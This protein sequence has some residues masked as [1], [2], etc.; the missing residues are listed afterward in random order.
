[1]IYLGD[2]TTDEDAFGVLPEAITIRVGAAPATRARFQ[3]PDPAA[4]CEFLSWLA[5]RESALPVGA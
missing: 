4:V 5:S 2:D 3:L 1:V